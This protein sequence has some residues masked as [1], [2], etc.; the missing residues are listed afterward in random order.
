M[1]NEEWG[2]LDK[3]Y[4]YFPYGAK[5]SLG[6]TEGKSSTLLSEIHAQRS[7]TQEKGDQ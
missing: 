1:P 6:Q 7:S 2:Y 5:N 3:C 4:S